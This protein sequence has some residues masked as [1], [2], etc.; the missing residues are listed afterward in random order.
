M[1]NRKEIITM[2]VNKSL[3]LTGASAL[4]GVGTF[5]VNAISKKDETSKIAEE[6]AK[7][8]MEKQKESK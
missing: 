7:I 5:V 8:V 4:L 6:A 2:K 1:E 3:L